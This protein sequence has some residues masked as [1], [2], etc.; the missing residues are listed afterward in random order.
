MLVC[1][2]C[3]IHLCLCVNIQFENKIVLL[4]LVLPNKISS[5]PPIIT[6]Y[7]YSFSR[8]EVLSLRIPV[9]GGGI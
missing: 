4:E 2:L 1:F 8:R 9:N 5:L 3:C 7:Y 6:N